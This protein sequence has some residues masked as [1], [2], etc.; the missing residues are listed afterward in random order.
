MDTVFVVSGRSLE[1]S[2]HEG[3]DGH[4]GIDH[5]KSCSFVF[6]VNFVNFVVNAA[7]NQDLKYTLGEHRVKDVKRRRQLPGDG[8]NSC[9]EFIALSAVPR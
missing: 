5:S 7:R 9:R 3:H 2:N 8:A 6:F 4:E 1:S